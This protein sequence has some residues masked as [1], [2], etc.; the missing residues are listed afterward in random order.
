MRGYGDTDALVA[1]L[2]HVGQHLWREPGIARQATPDLLLTC[3][4]ELIEQV[5]G[6]ARI[7]GEGCSH[8]QRWVLEQVHGALL[9]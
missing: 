3:L 9:R 6:S 2:R 7:G 1:L 4:P 8:N 5:V